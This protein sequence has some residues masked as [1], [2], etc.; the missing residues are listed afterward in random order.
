MSFYSIQGLLQDVA[1]TFLI[2]TGSII[3]IVK[4]SIWRKTDPEC[5]QL[6]D[7]S[8]PHLVG[9]DGRPLKVEGKVIACVSLGDS[10][11]QEPLVVIEQLSTD[12][13]LGLDFLE[14][15]RCTIDISARQLVID[16]RFSLPLEAEVKTKEDTQSDKPVL[17]ACVS[18]VHV[19][20]LLE[21]E[22]EGEVQ[23]P[24]NGAWMVEGI[25][26]KTNIIT[27]RALVSPTNAKSIQLRVLNPSVDTV[28]LYKGTKVAKLEPVKERITV[29]PVHPTG[30]TDSAEI[31]E[32]LEE[33]ANQCRQTLSPKELKQLLDVLKKH[34]NVFAVSSADL[35]RAT[36]IQHRI[37]TGEQPPIRQPV[38]RLP[39][40][41][42][43]QAR[44]DLKEMEK[45]GV[46][47]PSTSPWAS[48]LVLVKKKDGSLRFCVDYRRLNAVTRK[49]DYP[50]PRIDESLD[51]LSGSY[52][53]TTLD[54]LSGYW[55]VEV[56]PADKAKTAVYT[57]E[58]LFE[59]NVMPFRFCN[60]PATFQHLMNCVLAGLHWES[61]LVY[62][63]DVIVLWKSFPEHLQNLQSFSAAPGIWTE[64]E[65]IQVHPLSRESELSGSCGVAEWCFH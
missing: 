9:V 40:G 14:K 11:S 12:A 51:T 31:D 27:A 52:L 36:K 17:V 5:H 57:P 18:T 34:R 25:P 45:R 39:V 46:I 20:P 35:G 16:E 1:A 30:T 43:E 56:H 42:R 19:P 37:W 6:M 22:L 33:L 32:V 44:E 55:Q 10:T 48:P 26:I 47:Q 3:S 64:V 50:I 49:D 54:L 4:A 15:Y 13:I 65:A 29:A 58:G 28:T 62:V 53:F 2:D 63:D 21:M 60:A 24:V 59:F 41:Q 38:R 61:C 8:G 23:E 7:Y